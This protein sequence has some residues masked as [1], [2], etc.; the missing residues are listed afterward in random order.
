MQ[1]GPAYDEDYTY[2]HYTIYIPKLIAL[3]P[4]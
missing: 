3:M 2:I 4:L 1:A